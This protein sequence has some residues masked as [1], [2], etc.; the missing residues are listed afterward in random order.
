MQALLARVKPDDRA[1]LR[2]QIHYTA[3]CVYSAYGLEEQAA[4]ALR[5]AAAAL[6]ELLDTLPVAARERLRQ[7][8]PLHRAVADALAA[9]ALAITRRLARAEV[10]LGRHLRD[11]DYVVIGWTLSLPD[12]ER[13]ARPDERRRH[14][15]RRLLRE[16]AEQG[17]AP[18][19]DDLAGALG[20]S[21]RTILRDMAALSAAGE[22]LTT[23]RRM[24]Q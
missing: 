22:A 1:E 20:V 8:D 11:A 15:L 9:S 14:V 18:I 3:Y 7:G 21:H 17:A 23:R 4:E 24:S 19:D 6:H 16:A 10:P 12:D 2:E 5:R 13:F